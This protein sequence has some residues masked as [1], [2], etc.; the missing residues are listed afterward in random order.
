MT[1]RNAEISHSS[2]LPDITLN[3]YSLSG[4]YGK[5]Y[6]MSTLSIIIVTFN[7]SW[8]LEKTLTSIFQQTYSDYQVI[9]IDGKSTDNTL[10]IIKNYE[11]QIWHWVSEKDDGIYDAMNKG[12]ATARGEYIQFLN[13]GDWFA[14]SH[15][16][17]EVFVKNVVR[18]TL[19]YGNI[20]RVDTDGSSIVVKA[21]DFD[22]QNLLRFGTG[23]LCHQAMFVRRAM[24]P[25]YETKYKFKGELNWYFDLVELDSFSYVRY[26][27]TIVDYGLGGWG[28]QHFVRNRVDWIR[29][30]YNRYGLKVILDNKLL[31]FL[32]K[33]SFIRYP[34][35]RKIHKVV[36]LP[37]RI[38]GKLFPV[39]DK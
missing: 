1:P 38:F 26:D 37:S 25:L 34:W 10:D 36:S 23:V 33:N 12:L 29:L 9:V 18:P 16:L 24:S 3:S 31:S 15:V 20:N 17:E 11:S 30:V 2:E 35:L 21:R 22:K 39:E 32:W 14:D 8:D 7:A 5:N 28:Y 27:R 6:S 4:Q 19:I 13:A